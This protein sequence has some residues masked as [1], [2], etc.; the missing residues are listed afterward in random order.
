MKLVIKMLVTLTIVGVISGALLSE[1]SGW[2]EPKIEAH[3]KAETE[4]AIFEVQ[5]SAESYEVVDGID[6]ECYKVFDKNKEKTGY[7]LT[8]S[9]SGFQG[10]IRLMIGMDNSLEKVLGLKVLEQV[11]T[12]GLGTKITEDDFTN[13]FKGLSAVP[14]IDWVKGASPSKPNEIQAITGATISSKAVV[15]IMNDG[16]EKLR[17]VDGGKK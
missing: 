2:A 14:G 3:R 6:F 5:P 12:P 7:A 17:A 16:I 8:Y 4:K 13:Q 1:I 9:G 10:K 15:S 11:E